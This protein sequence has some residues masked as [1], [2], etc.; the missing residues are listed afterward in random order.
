MEE[1]IKR[2]LN[3]IANIV[4]THESGNGNKKRIL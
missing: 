4:Y 3:S 1:N 2:K